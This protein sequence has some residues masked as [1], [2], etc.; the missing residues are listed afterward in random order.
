M[1]LIPALKRQRQTDL[2]E[3]E[4]SWVDKVSS[5]TARATDKLCLTK[6]CYHAY[7]KLSRDLENKIHIHECGTY[8]VIEC[9]SVY[10]YSP[11]IWNLF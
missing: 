7:P 5:R 9:D 11:K 3:F 6:V 10:Y 1:P 4:A 2:C 8:L